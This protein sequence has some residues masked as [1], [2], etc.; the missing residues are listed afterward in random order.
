MKRLFMATMGLPKAGKTTFGMSAFTSDHLDP[1]RVVYIDNHNSTAG[2]EG[3]PEYNRKSGSGVLEVENVTQIAEY[4][5]E[6]ERKMARTGKRPLDC[7]ILDDITELSAL[8]I[9]HLTEDGPMNMVKW[10]QHKIFMSNLYRKVKNVSEH[11][12]FIGRCEWQGSPDEQ[13]DPTSVGDLRTQEMQIILEGSFK[14]WFIYDV[15]ILAY[16][17][18]QVSGSGRAKFYMQLQRT[19]DVRV[20]NRLWSGDPRKLEAPSFDGLCEVINKQEEE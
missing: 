6:M 12:L 1:E 14:N 4:L 13:P 2:A 19:D 11:G 15:A 17:Y 20:E 10:G 5:V 9:A 16:Q 8:S 18:K 3:L 7:V